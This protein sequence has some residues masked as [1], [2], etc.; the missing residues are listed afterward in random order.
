M[1]NDPKEYLHFGCCFCDKPLPKAK[2]I[3]RGFGIVCQDCSIELR[4]L[5]REASK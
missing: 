5:K 1:C 2:R 4:R 3:A